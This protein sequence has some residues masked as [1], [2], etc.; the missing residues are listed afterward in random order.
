VLRRRLRDR[1][2][3]DPELPRLDDEYL[4]ELN[5]AYNHFFFHYTATPLLVVET[6]QMDLAWDEEAIADLERQ[7]RGMGR[8]TRYYV[9]RA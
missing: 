7:V 8:G 1:M 3:A 5:E 4:R 2:K 6:S 9:P